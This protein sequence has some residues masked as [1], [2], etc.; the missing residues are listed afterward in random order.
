MYHFSWLNKHHF[1]VLMAPSEGSNFQL[2]QANSP[3]AVSTRP[4]SARSWESARN[5]HQFNNLPIQ[6]A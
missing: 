2:K 6:I 5:K 4:Q 1:D 3:S